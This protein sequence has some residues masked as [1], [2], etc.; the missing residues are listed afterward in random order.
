MP[1]KNS[2]NVLWK[3]VNKFIW[4]VGK[5]QE[6]TLMWFWHA[7]ALE[8]I[9]ELNKLLFHTQYTTYVQ[10]YSISRIKSP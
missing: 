7:V 3:R 9:L 1:K 4:I 5:K 8:T 10:K 2:K 6:L